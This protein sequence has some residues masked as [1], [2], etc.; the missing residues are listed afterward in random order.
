ML[1]LIQPVDDDCRC[2]GIKL[3]GKVEIVDSFEDLR[4]QVTDEYPGGLLYGDKSII[5]YL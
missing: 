3:N 2:K 4:I 5:C 1:L